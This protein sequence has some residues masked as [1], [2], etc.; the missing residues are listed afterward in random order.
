[1]TF[2]TIPILRIFDEEKAREFYLDFLGMKVDWEYRIEP[3]APIYMQVSRGELVFHLSEN[4]GDGTLGTKIFVDVVDVE[5]L[6]AE[7][8]GKNYRY[9]RPGLQDAFWGAKIMEVIDP[10]SNRVI[11]NESR[12][13]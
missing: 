12:E 4:S 1:M 10:F 6:H 3:G 7:V 8:S 9:N 5:S 13:G 11:F 2:K